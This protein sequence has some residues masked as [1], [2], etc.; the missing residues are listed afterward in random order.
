[1][2]I[3][4]FSSLTFQCL[5]LTLAFLI[6]IF[7]SSSIFCVPKQKKTQTKINTNLSLNKY[8]GKLDHDKINLTEKCVN[9]IKHLV[10]TAL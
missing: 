9:K 6:D 8:L 10:F 2:F 1:M 7:V 5:H 3:A 4:K